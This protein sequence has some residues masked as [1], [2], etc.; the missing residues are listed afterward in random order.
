MHLPHTQRGSNWESLNCPLLP[1]PVGW[2]D[3]AARAHVRKQMPMPAMDCR[4]AQM[5]TTL[6]NSDWYLSS[7]SNTMTHP[8]A[9]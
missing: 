8:V 6:L 3:S 7:M 1:R 2:Q 5:H 4:P 9:S